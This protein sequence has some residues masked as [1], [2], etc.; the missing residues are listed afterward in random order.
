MQIIAKTSPYIRKATSTKRMMVDVLIALIPVIGFAI[1]KFQFDFILRALVASVLAVGLEAL[2]FGLMKERDETWK[3]RFKKY[4]INNIVPPIITALIFVLTLPSKVDYYAVIIG[5]TFAIIIGKMIFGGLG[6]N[7]FNPAGIGRVFVAVA[8]GGL[9]GSYVDNVSG[10]TALTNTWS[11]SLLNDF[12]L[13][14]LFIGNVPGS[15]GEISALAILIGAVY[16]VVRRSA[17][18]RVIVSGLLSFT[19]LMLVAGLGL[20]H[21]G[22]DL[23]NFV[24]YQVLAG[25]LLFGLVFMATDPVTSPYTRP[26]RLI[27]GLI[28]GS[29][30][31]I[32]RLFGSFPEGMVFA[33][34]TANMFVALIDY[35]KWTTNVYTK[36][37]IIGYSVAIVVIAIIVFLGTGGF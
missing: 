17:D 12:S 1:Y 19:L 7:I 6:R 33:L 27:F 26:G 16:L 15:M 21:E 35:K 10:A 37:F 14:D 5:I 4:T 13:V 18:F 24:L 23:I 20:K 31:A 22:M 32:I 30:V 3:D 28:I 9:M 29:L 36:K 2:A 8:M 34:V 11:P 25:G